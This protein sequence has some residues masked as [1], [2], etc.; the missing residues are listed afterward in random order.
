MKVNKNSLPQ[1][2]CSPPHP[3]PSL[4][5]LD[6]HNIFAKTAPTHSFPPFWGGKKMCGK[7][8]F[9]FPLPLFNVNNAVKN[10]EFLPPPPPPLCNYRIIQAQTILMK[11]AL[12]FPSPPDKFKVGLLMGGLN[13]G[14]HCTPFLRPYQMLIKHW[15]SS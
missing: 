8:K 4:K 3:P 2:H 12:L 7:K 15:G 6:M 14:M 5:D 1:H 11:K 13:E 9:H 10:L